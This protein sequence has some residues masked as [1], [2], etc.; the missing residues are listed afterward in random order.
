MS[1]VVDMW[2]W[3]CWLAGVTSWVLGFRMG[4]LMWEI[5]ADKIRRVNK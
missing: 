1:A 4:Q 3:V 2:L 5:V